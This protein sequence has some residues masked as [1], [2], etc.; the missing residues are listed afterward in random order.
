MTL[1]NWVPVWLSGKVSCWVLWWWNNYYKA[2]SCWLCQWLYCICHHPKIQPP[3]TGQP[4]MSAFNS[5]VLLKHCL[6]KEVFK[7]ENKCKALIMF[8]P[9]F[10][11]LSIGLCF[12]SLHYWS[13]FT[14]ANISLNDYEITGN[15][16]VWAP[17]PLGLMRP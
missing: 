15:H 14:A 16:A 4:V 1:G 12:F 17:P 7:F 13:H 10:I 5:L 2:C 11:K 9:H 6:A 8:S 3:E